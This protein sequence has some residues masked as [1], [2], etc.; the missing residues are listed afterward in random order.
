MLKSVKLLQDSSFD[1]IAGVINEALKLGADSNFGHDY[2]KDFEQ[3]FIVKVRDPISTG[4]PYMD[5]IV[6]QGLGKGELGVVIAPTGAGKSM[7]LVHL[8]TQALLGW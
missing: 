1:E 6:S 8:G 4:W 2:L 5:E 7:A 3:R